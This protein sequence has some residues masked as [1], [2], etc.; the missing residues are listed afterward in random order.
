MNKLI[1][2]ILLV[3]YALSIGIPLNPMVARCM[4]A[5]TDDDYETLKL[6]VKFPELPNQING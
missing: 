6:D 3:T 1:S 4:I 5:Y 2:L